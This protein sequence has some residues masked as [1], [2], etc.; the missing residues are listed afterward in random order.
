[1]PR[2]R[3]ASPSASPDFRSPSTSRS[4]T[5]RASSDC[6]AVAAARSFGGGICVSSVGMSS[7]NIQNSC[8]TLLVMANSALQG[9]ATV[10]RVAGE[11]ERAP[12]APVAHGEVGW[13]ELVAE[14]E[15]E[16]GLAAQLLGDEDAGTPGVQMDHHHPSLQGGKQAVLLLG[17]SIVHPLVRPQPLTAPEGAIHFPSGI[18]LL[19]VLASILVRLAPDQPQLDL[20]LALLEVKHERDDGIAPFAH[21]GLPPVQLGPVQ[22]EL[23]GA[24]RVVGEGRGRPVRR[25]PQGVKVQL[26]PRGWAKASAIWTAPAR[27][28]LTSL[29]RS[30]S[31]ASSVSSTV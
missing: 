5:G 31:P 2:P 12:D 14:V 16:V 22:Q 6:R 26:P 25:D 9:T 7:G 10:K 4:D 24:D 17:G 30:A 18:A 23:P 20:G 8:V 1:M 3:G 28:L 11:A 19:D 13:D 27:R 15:A 21:L 29:P